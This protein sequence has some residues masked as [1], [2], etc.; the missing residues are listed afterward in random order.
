MC[1]CVC[2]CMCVCVWISYLCS[3]LRVYLWVSSRNA[4]TEACSLLQNMHSGAH[5]LK[6]ARNQ[7]AFC[8]KWLILHI[9]LS[10]M[11]SSVTRNDLRMNSLLLFISHTT[12]C[13]VLNHFSR[14]WLFATPWTVAHLLWLLCSWGCSRQEYW[15]GLPFPPPG[16]GS[17]SP[18]D[19]THVSYVSCIGRWVLYH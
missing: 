15:S 2:V 18:R 14:V 5:S 4:R 17:S 3:P 9:Q 16:D 19:W 8:L 13:A 6:C 10:L 12:M 7:T 1:V 11:K